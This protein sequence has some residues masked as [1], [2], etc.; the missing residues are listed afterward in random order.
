MDY[1]PW[2]SPGQ[3]TG[4]SS[5]F[6]LQRVFPTQG[7]NPGLLHYRQILYQLSHK[8]STRILK[9][10]AYCFSRES[11]RP[12]NWT[13]VSCI[14]GGFFTKWAIREANI[15]WSLH[16]SFLVITV[17]DYPK[18]YSLPSSSIH[19]IFQARILEWVAL[20]ISGRSSWPR[21]WT[22]VSCIVG[23]HFTIWV[24]REVPNN[25]V[26]KDNFQRFPWWSS[27]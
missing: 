11:S 24:T 19:G 18:D 17:V 5:L 22:Q 14:P 4:V 25:V 1:S 8:G 12:R 26:T 23:R 20:S 10:V 3:N 7:L 13:G 9:W 21:G 6:L 15:F 27:G 16:L 2:N